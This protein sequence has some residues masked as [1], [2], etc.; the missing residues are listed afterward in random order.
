M[1]IAADGSETVGVNCDPGEVATGGGIGQNNGAFLD[2]QSVTSGPQVGAG[3]VPTGWAV[4]AANVDSDDDGMDTIAVAAFV[5][6][7][8]P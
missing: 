3:D 8:S 6:C 5:V 4:R 7:A 1:T 2:M